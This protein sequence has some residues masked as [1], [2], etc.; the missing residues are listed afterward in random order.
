MKCKK[1]K[2]ARNRSEGNAVAVV[3]YFPWCIYK[4]LASQSRDV[5]T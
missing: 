5:R 2:L 1:A 4:A 3:N